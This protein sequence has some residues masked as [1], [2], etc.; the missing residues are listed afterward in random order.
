[1]QLPIAE[2]KYRNTKL[3]NC[4][5]ALWFTGR[6]SIP[7]V[8]LIAE[9]KWIPDLGD[10]NLMSQDLVANIFL[11][12]IIIFSPLILMNMTTFLRPVKCVEISFYY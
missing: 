9:M 4:K 7:R 2:P 11:L 3:Y 12:K 1:M 5:T 6:D 8:K 10:V